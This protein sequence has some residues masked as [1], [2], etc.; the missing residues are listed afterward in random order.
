MNWV[1]LIVAVV[2]EVIGTSALKASEG[3]SR[4]WP[5]LIVV[6]GY[7]SAFYFLSLTLRAIPV[8]IAYALWS[9][10][11][12]VLISLAGWAVF[13]QKLDAAAIGGIVLIIAGVLVIN[14]FSNSV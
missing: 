2:S 6:A 4:L 13:G 3:F 14:L 5:S 12:I 1:Y 10:I 9:G 8:G 7:S 11:G